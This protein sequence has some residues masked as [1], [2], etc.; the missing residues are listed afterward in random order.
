MA[1]SARRQSRSPISRHPAAACSAV[2]IGVAPATPTLTDSPSPGASSTS[3]LSTRR[4]SRSATRAASLGSVCGRRTQNSSPPIRNGWSLSRSP[5]RNASPSAS[6][7]AS[8]AACPQRS[9]T[10]L[11]RSTSTTISETGWPYRPARRTSAASRSSN[12]RRFPRPVSGSRRARSCAF[13]R[14]SC[15]ERSV[16]FRRV[17]SSIT[18]TTHG[19]PP[20]RSLRIRIRTSSAPPS[21]SKRKSSSRSRSASGSSR[22]ARTAPDSSRT[23]AHGATSPKKSR[24]ITSPGRVPASSD[25][26]RL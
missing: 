11:K 17:L 23:S 10:S 24:P 4:W 1:S 2:P 12:H 20:S 6:R 22:A 26:A 13:S 21:K 14:A 18:S 16:S 25:S 3:T 5:S 7:A 19:S 8:P 9:F 15:S